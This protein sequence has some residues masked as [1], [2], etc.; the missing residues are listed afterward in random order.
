MRKI[1]TF[2]SIAIVFFLIC[3][4]FPSVIGSNNVTIKKY[5]KSG[6]QIDKLKEI[7]NIYNDINQFQFKD[8]IKRWTPGLFFTLLAINIEFLFTMI[9]EGNWV[10]GLTIYAILLTFIQFFVIILIPF[11][12][13]SFKY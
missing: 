4:S 13:I 9:R 11:P 7:I 1:I 2:G 10:P 8:N 12:R 3:S 5:D 6:I